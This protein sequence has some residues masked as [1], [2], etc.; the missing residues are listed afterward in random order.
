MAPF[1]C[2]RGRGGP[3]LEKEPEMQTKVTATDVLMA[4]F[5][6]LAR[7]VML[8]VLNRN[9]CI[10]SSKITVDCLTQF[11]LTVTAH[12]VKFL[13]TAPSLKL[14][15]AAGTTERGRRL[16]ADKTLNC[17]MVAGLVGR[18]MLLLLSVAQRTS[19][20]DAS[21]DQASLPDR[22]MTIPPCMLILPIPPDA[23]DTDLE[24]TAVLILDDGLEIKVQY[25][26]TNDDSFMS[27]DAWNDED[28][29]IFA[30]VIRNLIIEAPASLYAQELMMCSIL[31][32]SG[33]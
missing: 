33:L 26:P 24:I 7:P 11:G 29:I 4:R 30:G 9:S 15:Y 22:G 16:T 19:Y 28:T 27:T 18:D 2:C 23:P 10:A 21:F 8:K 25:F 5:G 31:R 3:L 12:A 32:G 13:V 20:L 6:R 1:S 14:V 17:Q